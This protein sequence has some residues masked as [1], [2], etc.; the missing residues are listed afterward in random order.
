[1]SQ[2]TASKRDV[3]LSLAHDSGKPPYTPAAFFL[4]FDPAFH[5][6][7]AAVEKHL[8]FFARLTWISSRF[9]MNSASRPLHLSAALRIGPPCRSTR[10]IFLT[11]RWR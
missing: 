9:N 10:T 6:G 2:K 11:S 7:Q 3:M 5:R 4:H 1:M 8:E